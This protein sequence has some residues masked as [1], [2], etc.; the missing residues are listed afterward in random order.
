[1]WALIPI[2]NMNESKHRLESILSPNE[3]RDLSEAMLEDV[4]T[5]VMAV[6]EFE[7]V[8]VATMCPTAKIIS[9]R[10][11]ASVFST[12]QDEGQTAAVAQATAAFE[13]EGITSMLMLPGDVPLVTPEE[14]H[15]VL[16]IHGSAPAM[17][18]VPARDEQGSN[19]IVL[20]PPTATNLRFGSNSYFPHL[21]AARKLSLDLR[22]PKLPGIGLDIDT[23]EDLMELCR[24]PLQTR[25]Q[26]Y[27]E[28]HKI[29]QRLVKIV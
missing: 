24:Q 1:M 5:T 6:P 26:E 13:A 21:D 18:I 3:R 20:S 7:K 27:L 16:E 12:G 15:R 10:H 28:N 29:S 14:I 23:P 17:T 4:L 25:A 22:T 2:K 19:C 8:A 9:M 11:G